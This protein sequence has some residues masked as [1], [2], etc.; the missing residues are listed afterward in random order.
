[1][2][3]QVRVTCYYILVKFDFPDAST[4]HFLNYILVHFDHPDGSTSWGCICYY[5]LVKFDFPDGSTSWVI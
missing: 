2:A 1:M 5:I 3:A 4:N